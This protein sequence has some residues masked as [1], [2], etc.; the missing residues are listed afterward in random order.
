MANPKIINFGNV[1][2]RMDLVEAIVRND[3]R[4]ETFVFLQH[5]KD[6]DNF[7][8]IEEDYEIVLMKWHASM[9]PDDKET[10]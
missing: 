2:I 5:S 8:S 9:T 7:Y 10:K 4:K 6:P 1:A 3:K